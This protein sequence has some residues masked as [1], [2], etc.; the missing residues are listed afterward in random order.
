MNDEPILFTPRQ[1]AIVLRV[2]R[3]TVY[4]LIKCRRLGAIHIGKRGIRVS[5]TEIGRFLSA[6]SRDGI[7]PI[8]LPEGRSDGE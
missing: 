3:A 4:E 8:D 6:N 5:A 1:V 7:Y 2:S